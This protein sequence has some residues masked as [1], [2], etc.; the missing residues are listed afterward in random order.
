[1]NPS[2]KDLLDAVNKLPTDRVIILPNNKNILMAAKQAAEEANGKQICVVEARTVPQGISA[3][4]ALDPHGELDDVCENMVEMMSLVETGEITTA[5][6]DAHV[7][8]LEIAEG[9]IIGLHNGK[10]RVAGETIADVVRGLLEE[11]D[12]EMLELISLFYGEDI[13]PMDAEALVDT[14]RSDYP[15]HEFEVQAGGQPHYFYIISAE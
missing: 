5:V 12:I 15:E 11:M 14:L 8:G 2:T 9:Q 10:M 3:Q 4:L 13:S 1:M 6:R 7:D